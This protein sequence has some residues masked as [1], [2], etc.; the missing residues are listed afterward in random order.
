MKELRRR[1][2]HSLSEIVADLRATLA[3][4]ARMKLLPHRSRTDNQHAAN[5]IRSMDCSLYFFIGSLSRKVRRVSIT[6]RE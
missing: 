5:I 1:I 2:Y 6:Q 3:R 4:R